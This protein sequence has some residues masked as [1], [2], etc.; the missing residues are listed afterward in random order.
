M[1][2]DATLVTREQY[3]EMLIGAS[4]KDAAEIESGFM[5]WCE[6]HVPIWR[7][8]GYDETWVRQR[9]ETAQATHS[10]HCKFKEQSLAMLESRDELRKAYATHLL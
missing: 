2:D 5:G 1:E 8:Q 10:L 6:R 3:V 4:F 7:E 9:I